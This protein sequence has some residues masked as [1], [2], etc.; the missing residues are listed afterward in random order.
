MRKQ[1]NKILNDNYRVKDD[2]KF[3]K[4]LVSDCFQKSF[5]FGNKFKSFHFQRHDIQK[6]I[7]QYF[8]KQSRLIILHKFW[9]NNMYNWNEMMYVCH[10]YNWYHRKIDNKYTINNNIMQ[11]KKKWTENER[12]S[13]K[14]IFILMQSLY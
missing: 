14:D 10:K 4:C 9:L 2:I 5:D 8:D 3:H 6:L 13:W 12:T 7:E 1:V 11:R